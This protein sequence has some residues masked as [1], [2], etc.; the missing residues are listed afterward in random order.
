MDLKRLCD[1]DSIEN[2]PFD[3]WTVAGYGN[4]QDLWNADSTWDLFELLF[5]INLLDNQTDIAKSTRIF[6]RQTKLKPVWCKVNL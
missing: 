6:G 2:G 4:E 3:V 5:D 1:Q